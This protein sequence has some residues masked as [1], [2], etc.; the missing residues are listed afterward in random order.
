MKYTYRPVSDI[1]PG[2]TIEGHGKVCWIIMDPKDSTRRL[3]I[4]ED[5]KWSTWPSTYNLPVSQP[6]VK[7]A[8]LQPHQRIKNPDTDR[9]FIIDE[10][11]PSKD[12][13][14]QV[15]ITGWDEFEN[16]VNR[17]WLLIS[18]D[19]EFKLID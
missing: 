4:F 1:I 15:T 12:Y 19:T 10:V 5:G 17:T 3:V 14:S 9:I 18:P 2:Q 8:D 16:S 7:A 11:L 6:R 13:P